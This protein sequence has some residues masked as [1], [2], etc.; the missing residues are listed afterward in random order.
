MP[1]SPG[2]LYVRGPGL[3]LGYK[4]RTDGKDEQ[5]WFRT[6]DMVYAREGNYYIIGR[7]KDLIKV[8]GQVPDSLNSFC[9]FLPFI[10]HPIQLTC[11][12]IQGTPL[13]QR[14]L[15]GFY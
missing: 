11:C 1:D 10:G 5:G 9:F 15:K 14:R 6:G 3:L 7:T 13:R 12:V 4:G 8:R 2:E